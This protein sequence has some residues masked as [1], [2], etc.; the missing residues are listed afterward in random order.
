M[1]ALALAIIFHTW[2][3]GQEQVRHGG[4]RTKYFHLSQGA[5]KARYD[6]M[7]ADGLGP[8]SLKHFLMLEDRLLKIE[9]TS[10]CSGH[11]R[12]QEALT[13]SNAIKDA[14]VGY[15]FSYHGVHV[16]Q[17]SEPDKFIN[18]SLIC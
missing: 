14:F 3:V 8:E 12:V 9:Q 1:A 6:Q 7:R 10:V 4:Y 5:S 13:V 17:V 2:N 15:D 16:K 11:P 18:Q